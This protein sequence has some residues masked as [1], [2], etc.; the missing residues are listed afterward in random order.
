MFLFFKHICGVVEH[1][2]VFAVES[3]WETVRKAPERLS[4]ICD[5]KWIDL[6]EAM[7]SLQVDAFPDSAPAEDKPTSEA[8]RAAHIRC[9]TTGSG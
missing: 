8:V 9:L 4:C 7:L 6:T 1:A 2:Q 5:G 3:P